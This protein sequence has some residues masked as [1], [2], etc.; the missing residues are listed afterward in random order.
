MGR[1]GRVG[2]GS[3]VEE[4]IKYQK[5]DTKCATNTVLNTRVTRENRAGLMSSKS[6]FFMI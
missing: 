6:T 1:A 2:R 5:H 4:V 3:Y